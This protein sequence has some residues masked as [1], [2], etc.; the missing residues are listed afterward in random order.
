[1]DHY[2]ETCNNLADSGFSTTPCSDPRVLILGS[3][4]SRKSLER[5]EYYGNPK[6]HFW[7]IMEVL[8][9]I[10]STLPYAVRIRALGEHRIALWD[11]VRSCHRTGSMDSAIREPA[12]NDIPVFIERNPKLRLIALNGTTAKRY[13]ERFRLRDTIDV[14]TLPSTSPAHAR[15]TIREKTDCWSIICRYIDE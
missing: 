15:L 11:L 1:M 3:F 5:T 8:L 14:L 7:S 6:N 10:D 9:S 12:L 2:D 4:P 13:F